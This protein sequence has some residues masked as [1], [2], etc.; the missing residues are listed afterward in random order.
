MNL[1][2]KKVSNC[3]GV[4][5][6]LIKGQQDVIDGIIDNYELSKD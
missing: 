2:V 5:K 3:D 6:G 4:H 1:L